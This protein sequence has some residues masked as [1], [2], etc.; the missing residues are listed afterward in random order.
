[1]PNRSPHIPLSP[2]TLSVIIPVHNGGEKFKLCLDSV[3]SSLPDNAEILIVADGESD[4]S[5]QY[6]EQFNTHIIKNPVPGGPAK[7]RNLGAKQAKGQ[8]LFFID[9][10][11]TIKEN[12]IQTVID[13]F[14]NNPETHALMGSYD[15]DPFEKN[16]LSQYKNL[17]HHYTHQNGAEQS[18]TFWTAC[19][20]IRKDVFMHVNGFDENRFRP[21]RGSCPGT[22]ED[23]ELGYRLKEAG[24]SI[25]LLKT[26]QV[27][28]LKKWHLGSFL[29]TEFFYRALPWAEL[30]LQKGRMVNDLNLKT[31][32]RVSIILIF[33]ILLCLAAFAYGYMPAGYAAIS[34][35]A[36][37]L[38]INL[39]CY[40]FFYHKK[41]LF[42]TLLVIP[43]HW[44]YFF[45]SGLAYLFG[46]IIFRFKKP[47]YSSS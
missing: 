39:S 4:G 19:G 10:D 30:L 47:T 22:I 41:G 26:L 31:T 23:V 13:F 18:S 34:L 3:T 43:W 37:L 24:Y 32:T 8:L 42:F 5:W 36:V 2:I 1:M 12:T 40:K 28:H 9:S 11:V 6:A 38:I 35:A 27:K 29:K 21:S 7:A 17:F 44:L 20:A 15:D 46:S 25:R 16:F 33:T 14:K 45:Y